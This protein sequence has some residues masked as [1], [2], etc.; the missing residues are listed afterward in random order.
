GETQHEVKLT[1]GFWLAKTETTQ[2]QWESVMGDNPSHFKGADL[3]VE[4][5]SWTDCQ[6]WL[7]KMN[8]KHPLP[9]GWKWELPTNA[10]WEYACRAGTETAFSFGNAL[11]G[12]EANCDG[13]Y[14]YPR[15]NAEGPNLGKT[16]KVG[17][18]AANAW[19]LHDMHGNVAEMCRDWDTQSWWLEGSLSDGAIDPVGPVSGSFRVYRGGSWRSGARESR[20]ASRRGASPDLR[21]DDL[22][23][24][25]ALVP[26]T[27]DRSKGK[28]L[29]G[30]RKWFKK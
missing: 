16:A 4:K 8:K 10:Q 27:S 6:E 23:F 19:S 22:G 13:S 18:Y 21:N 14:P 5:V 12:K 25:P 7:S 9:K 15:T 28:W 2:R 1:R 20:S 30:G 26:T 3:P 24:R 29:K 17:S 11:N